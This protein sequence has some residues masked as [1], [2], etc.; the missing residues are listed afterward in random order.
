MIAGFSG[1]TR[2][3]SRMRSAKL[4]GTDGKGVSARAACL[5]SI[6]DRGATDRLRILQREGVTRS[7]RRRRG[8]IGVS[9]VEHLDLHAPIPGKCGFRAAAG[10]PAGGPAVAPDR[11]TGVDELVPDVGEGRAAGA[12]DQET[13]LDEKT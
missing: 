10:G 8:T 11:E 9:R 7:G 3:W 1:R 4:D 12:I 5:E 13:G 2:A 6:I